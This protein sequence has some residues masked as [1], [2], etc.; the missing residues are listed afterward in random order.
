MASK[1]YNEEALRVRVANSNDVP[2]LSALGSDVFWKTYGSTAPEDDIANHV[3]SYFSEAAVTLEVVRED[4][5]Y[6]MAVED[7]SCAGLVKMRDSEVPVLASADSAMEVQQLYVSPQY[8]RRGIGE[9]LMDDVVRRVRARSIA[10]VWLSV[11]TNAPWATEFY[12]KYGFTS[13]GEIPFLMGETEFVDQLMWLS[14][15]D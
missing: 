8:Q 14:V 1:M 9:L 12:T 15:G 6:L 10:G 11:W 3:E 7:D 2:I 13:L 4:V 5:T